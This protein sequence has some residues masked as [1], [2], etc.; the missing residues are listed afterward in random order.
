MKKHNGA[1]KEM[2]YGGDISRSLSDNMRYLMDLTLT[3]R[4][5]S[6]SNNKLA[7][8]ARNDEI[9]DTFRI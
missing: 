6:R 1:E 9:P 8:A 7:K 3:N 4:T 2:F 5:V